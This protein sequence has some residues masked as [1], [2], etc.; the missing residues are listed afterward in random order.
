[1]KVVV[2]IGKPP[3][4]GDVICTNYGVK[5]GD[6]HE[7]IAIMPDPEKP[8]AMYIVAKTISSPGRAYPLGRNVYFSRY[9]MTAGGRCL[10][11]KYKPGTA[12]YESQVHTPPWNL[13][14]YDEI[15]IVSRNEQMSLF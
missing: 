2:P 3:Q 8:G 5:F 12:G 6:A 11:K 15:G 13:D 10:G 4:V 1:M 14:G 7:V 9:K